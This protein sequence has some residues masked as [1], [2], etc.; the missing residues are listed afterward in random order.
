MERKIVKIEFDEFLY[1]IF[2]AIMLVTKGIGLYDGQIIYKYIFVFATGILLIKLCLTQYK[3]IEYAFL[4]LLCLLGVVVYLKSR[5]KGV[6]ICTLTV[7]G[8]KNVSVKKVMRVGMW[9]WG[10]TM[11]I[12]MVFHTLFLECSGYQVHE[13]LGLGHIFRW[14]LGFL[15]PNV[16]HIA[17]FTLAIYVVY[18][19]WN[20]YDWKHFLLLMIG[21]MYVFLYSVSYT[22]ILVV[23]IYLCVALYLKKRKSINKL[24]CILFELVFP[25]LLALSFLSCFIFPEWIFNILNRIFSTRLSLARHFLVSEN[26]S[27]FGKRVA[28]LTT[29]QLTMDNS[30][31]FSLIIYGCVLFSVIV[32]GY[33]ALIHSCIKTSKFEELAIIITTL[34]AGV[35]EPFLFNTSFKNVTLVFLGSYVWER[36]KKINEQEIQLCVG[37]IIS[38]EVKITIFTFKGIAG[39][40]VEVWNNKKRKIMVVSVTIGMV[41]GILMALLYPQ[42]KGYIVPRK[43]MD[44][45]SEETWYLESEEDSRF[46]EYLVKDYVNPMTKMQIVEGN[47]VKVELL[48]NSISSAFFTGLF[49]VFVC[50]AFYV[51]RNRNSSCVPN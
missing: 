13:K 25:S 12:N 29:H 26:I 50:F 49:S 7:L 47:I 21:N 17:Y 28:E 48:R 42:P 15:H 39:A 8:M 10:I 32:L 6:I 33:I 20:A 4:V 5:E 37:R 1:I 22:G 27:L 31:I 34:I 45:V 24:E 51:A 30:Y 14:D 11:I 36:L 16:L 18:N 35:T 43:Q 19:Y 23:T 44:I 9:V 2:F 41:C 3:P 40:L 46:S 38:K